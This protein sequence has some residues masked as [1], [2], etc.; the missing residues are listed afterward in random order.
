[1]ISKNDCIL[2]LSEIKDTGV[3][4][5]TPVKLLRTSKETIPF[6]VIKFINDNRQ[7]DL[8]SFYEKLRKSYNAKK[9]KLYKNIFRET[10]D[11]QELLTTLASLNLQIY[12][13][14]KDVQ[15]KQMFLKHARAKEISYVM[16]NYCSTYDLTQCMKLLNLIKADLIACEIISDRRQN[17]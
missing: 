17:Y 11:A 15:D 14:S 3:D 1:M 6:D 5:S 7:L 4:I 8:T 2:L 12:L 16:A 13:F 9:S 10:T